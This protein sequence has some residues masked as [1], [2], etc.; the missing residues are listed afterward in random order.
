ML[1]LTWL[2][3]VSGIWHD[4]RGIAGY[5]GKGGNEINGSWQIDYIYGEKN[6]TS[7][8]LLKTIPDKDSSFKGKTLTLKGESTEHLFDKG[9]EKDSNKTQKALSI[10]ENNIGNY[11]VNFFK[12]L[13]CTC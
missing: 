8:H 11:T 7:H 2:L 9:A 5:W 1:H 3:R 4:Q 10:I 13:N 12:P 6:P